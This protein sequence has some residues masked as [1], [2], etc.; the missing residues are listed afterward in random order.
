MLF[1]F[2]NIFGLL[3]IVFY[4]NTLL[5]LAN[6][7]YTNLKENTEQRLNKKKVKNDKLSHF[8]MTL[9]S[10]SIVTTMCG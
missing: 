2:K 6:M 1:F 5:Y 4:S 7:S 9:T 10:V 3:Q 8:S